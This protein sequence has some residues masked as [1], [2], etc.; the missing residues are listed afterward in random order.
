MKKQSFVWIL[1]ALIAGC[2]IGGIVGIYLAERQQRLEGADAAL[3]EADHAFRAGQFGKALQLAF[4]A[5]DRRPN[6]A[7]AYELTGDILANAKSH[8]LAES[9]YQHSLTLLSSNT[10]DP[11][12]VATVKTPQQLQFERD[13]V[14]AKLK[15]F[16]STN[17]A[18]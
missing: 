13:R 9:L 3:L 10:A 8:D 7:A 1:A 4:S 16:Q 18:P 17:S 12:S 6:S 11:G 14:A 15:K 2:L 5:I